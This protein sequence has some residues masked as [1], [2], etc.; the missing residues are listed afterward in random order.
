[1]P[2]SKLVELARANKA[3]ILAEEED[4]MYEMAR[5][6]LQ[7]EKVIEDDLEFLAMKAAQMKAD[8]QTVNQAILLREE[9][10]QRLLWQV[11]SETGK[12]ATWAEELISKYQGIF[13]E[14]G[15]EFAAAGILAGLNEYG[16]SIGFGRLNV[17]A[18]E[19]MIG[20]AGD[21]SP[22]EKYLREIHGKATD[23]ILD[24]LVEGVAQGL[25]PQKIAANMADGFAGGL[26]QAMNTARTETLRA[27][28]TA[29]LMQYDAS[30]LVV[31][32]KRVSARDA[33]VC[34]GCL[35][36]DGQFYDDLSAFD[37]H[38]QGRCTLVP[39]LK[40]LPE[41]TW[42]SSED[43]FAGQPE[44]VQAQ[45]LGGGRFEAWKNGTPLEAMVKR[46]DHPIWGG[47]FV[48]TPV[49]ELGQ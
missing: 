4:A 32:Y 16:M 45:I 49:G 34:A 43:W 48:P 38:N 10:M 27:Y 19:A 31:G 20:F 14:Q 23:G 17:D 25:N 21:G 35:F 1:M 5:R 39:V 8:G 44:S 37:E 33:D 7:I 24:K 42:E 13:A 36:T 29:T 47:A 12:Y 11:R 26:Q 41:P 3:A 28:R 6:W 46:V 9:R 30:G 18:I 22:L 40:D 15:L 2:D